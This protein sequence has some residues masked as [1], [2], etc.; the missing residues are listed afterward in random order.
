MLAGVLTEHE[1]ALR[2]SLQSEYGI[3]LLTAGR[4]DPARS[5]YELAD[6]VEHLPSG[7]AL[8]RAQGGASAWPVG[9]LVVREVE[10]SLRMVAWQFA[11][12]Q[13]TRPVPL[14]LP[15]AAGHIERESEAL[16]TKAAAHA[17]RAERRSDSR[18]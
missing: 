13:G 5:P 14:K 12:A 17:R 7:C 8:G 2:A 3:R 18:N 9:A 1:G 10:H 11:G 6:L 15:E 4:T 16:S